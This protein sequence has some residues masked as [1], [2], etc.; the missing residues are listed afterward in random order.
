MDVR[1]IN[2]QSY[3]TPPR[4]AR[5]LYFKCPIVKT[6]VLAK[7]R[8][9]GCVITPGGHSSF[10]VPFFSIHH[11]GTFAHQMR[12]LIDLR[13]LIYECAPEPAA[14][15]MIRLLTFVARE[16]PRQE[17]WFVVDQHFRPR[18]FPALEGCRMLSLRSLPGRPGWACWYGWQ[19]PRLIRKRQADCL[20]S[21]GTGGRAGSLPAGIWIKG[22]GPNRSA[23]QK[24]SPAGRGWMKVPSLLKNADELV[25]FPGSDLARFQAPGGSNWLPRVKRISM[26]AGEGVRPL[27]W[28]EKEQVRIRYT[29]GREFFLVAGSGAEAR[30]V[31]LLKSFSLFKKR[32]QSNMQLVLATGNPARDVA[33]SEQLERYKFRADVIIPGHLGEGE[34]NR[35][36][37]G[38][39]ALLYGPGQGDPGTWLLNAF[40]CQT[41]VI[42][43][44]AETLSELG[45]D[46]QLESDF[47]DAEATAG[48]L[49]A[50]YKDEALRSGLIGK[51]EARV[52]P[53]A[54]TSS[55][56][57]VWHSIREA[58]KIK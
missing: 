2:E 10:T 8:K 22:M 17:W 41:P 3:I 20:V 39:Y 45:G 18:K 54:F 48:H 47:S 11:H 33:F 58:L 34:K 14:R 7:K 9:S 38:A 19:L 26:A 43:D 55:A 53:D 40:C 5:R 42:T 32:L 16:H 1:W 46:A 51:G 6:S 27:S 21:A 50:L 57:E 52:H 30:L 36:L 49:I 37:G 4:K 31:P 12:I 24:G 56:G 29:G 15:W 23:K 13:P 28:T 35:L 44:G 25:V